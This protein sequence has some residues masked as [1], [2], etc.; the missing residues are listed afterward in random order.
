MALNAIHA[1]D[2][3]MISSPVVLADLISVTDMI[4]IVCVIVENL[5]ADMIVTVC[6]IVENLTVDMIVTV[7]ASVEDF[8][9]ETIIVLIGSITKTTAALIDTSTTKIFV[10]TDLMSA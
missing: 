9:T 5:T 6:V 10:T 4:V 8:I 1:E 3:V 7:C 2:S